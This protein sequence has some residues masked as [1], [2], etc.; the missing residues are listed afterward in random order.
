MHHIIKNHG[1]AYKSL[2]LKN[3]VET[4]AIVFRGA[5]RDERVKMYRL[6]QIWIPYIPSEILHNLDVKIKEIDPEIPILPQ[7]L[8]EHIF[9]ILKDN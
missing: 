3:L 8:L 7:E 9:I 5:T 1:E 4:F 2:F 6:G